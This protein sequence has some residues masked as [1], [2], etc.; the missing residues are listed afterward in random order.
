MI[1]VDYKKGG[2]RTE[3][4]PQLMVDT[5]T[6]LGLKAELSDLPFG[7]VAFEGRGPD[8]PV[9]VGIERKTLRDM[10]HCIDDARLAGHQLIGMRHIYDVRVVML[11]GMWK[12]HDPQG[13]LMEGFHGGSS[14]GHFGVNP[15]GPTSQKRVLY[16]KLYRY[17]I[18]LSLS[19]VIVTLSRD[20]FQTCFDVGEWWG[21]FQKP[22]DRHTALQEIQKVNIP[23]LN[24]KPSLTRL[25]ANDIDEVGLKLSALAERHF[26][27]P[28]KLATS[29]EQDWLRI[30][31]IG[32]TTAQKIMRQI[33]G[34]RV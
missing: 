2:T 3:G 7:D 9:M 24:F 6:R 30:P 15:R 22:W 20:L 29:E 31:G 26:R 11:E 33:W 28:I 5:L 13:W 32:V 12:P 1:L 14:W 16:S 18:S 23:T 25:W 34:E 4:A 17:L 21:Y 19:G 8:G 27:T 10:L